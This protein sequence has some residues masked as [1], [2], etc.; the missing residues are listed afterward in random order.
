MIV[1]I[2]LDNVIPKMIDLCVDIHK[3]GISHIDAV[4]IAE[5]L[6]SSA[7][8]PVKHG[9]WLQT[10]DYYAY[11]CSCCGAITRQ[12]NDKYCHNCGAVMKL[13]SDNDVKTA[14]WE[15]WEGWIGNHDMRIEDATCSNCGYMHPTVRREFVNG[16][17]NGSETPQHVLNKL[18]DFCPSCRARMIKE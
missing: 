2:D 6:E 13:A 15:F 9:T 11:K 10:K 8:E 1:K 12:P 17:F 18:S 7:I 3:Q 14:K 16:K 4:R 5:L